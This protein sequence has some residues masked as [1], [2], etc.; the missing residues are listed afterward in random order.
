[1]FYPY[2]ITKNKCK[3][4]CNTINGPYAKSCVPNTANNENVK[5][6]NLMSRTNETRHTERHKAWKCK[7][8]SDASV[9]NNKQR[10][11]EDKCRCECK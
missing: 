8:R 10:W 3:G 7:C 6:F 1:M 9:C 5:V 2:S 11:N 4:S